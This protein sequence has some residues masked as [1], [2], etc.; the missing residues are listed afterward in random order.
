[1]NW[2]RQRDI[3]LDNIYYEFNGDATEMAKEI[4]ALRL[5]LVEL[6]EATQSAS[7]IGFKLKS[8]IQND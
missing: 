8:R 6:G 1:M 7:G 3:R 2:H 4:E 5:R